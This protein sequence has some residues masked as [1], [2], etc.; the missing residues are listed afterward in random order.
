MDL[1][2]RYTEVLIRWMERLERGE[3]PLI[4]GD[5]LQTMDF[6]DVRDVARANILAATSPATDMVL[7]VGSETETSLLELARHLAAAMGRPELAPVHAG[8]NRVNPVRRRLASTQAI[9]SHLGF[10]T[11]ISLDEGLRN[12]VAWWRRESAAAAAEVPVS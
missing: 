9:R 6:V 11:Q 8:E 10:Q 1:H 4:F 2:G 5:G 7:N 3:P 12:L